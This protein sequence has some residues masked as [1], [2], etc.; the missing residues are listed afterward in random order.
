MAITQAQRLI[1]VTEVFNNLAEVAA[2]LGTTPDAV[3][4]ALT[5]ALGVQFDTQMTTIMNHKVSQAQAQQ[6]SMNTMITNIS[7][8]IA[9]WTVT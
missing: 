9:A 2:V 1:A 3:I 6:A 4:N 5:I 7:A 8:A